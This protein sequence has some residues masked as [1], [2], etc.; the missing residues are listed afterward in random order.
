MKVCVSDKDALVVLVDR[1]AVRVVELPHAFLKLRAIRI[2]ERQERVVLE[3]PPLQPM[4][5]AVDDDNALLLVLDRDAPWAAK[6]IGLQA[7]CSE[8]GDE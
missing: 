5:T 1:D 8:L 4:A 3:R 2:D 6:L 7:A